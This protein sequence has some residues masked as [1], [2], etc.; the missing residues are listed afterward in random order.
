MESREKGFKPSG[1]NSLSPY[2]IVDDTRQWIKFLIKVFDVKELTRY[3]NPDGSLL[4]AEFQI[5]DTVIMLSGGS[6]Q[7]PPNKFMIHVF[8]T[9]A[10]DTFRKAIEAGCEPIE[11]PVQKMD[12]P[13]VRGMFR[14]FA[15]HVWAV[16]SRV[17][18]D[19][20]R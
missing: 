12:D 6:E 18:K 7:Y 17:Q 13:D 1:Y 14:D 15:G 10:P 16:A 20:A 2:F 8:V 5:D 19:N 11:E 9:D 4:H 3:N